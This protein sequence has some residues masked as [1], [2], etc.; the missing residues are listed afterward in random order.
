MVSKFD[1]F[2]P[3]TIHSTAEWME[4]LHLVSQIPSLVISSWMASLLPTLC[5]LSWSIHQKSILYFT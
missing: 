3:F 2:L 4:T 1:V 5:V